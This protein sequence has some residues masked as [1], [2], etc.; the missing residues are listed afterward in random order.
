MLALTADDAEARLVPDLGG[1]LAGLWVDGKPVLRPWS[2]HESE[3]PFALACNILVP[4]SNRIAGGFTFQGT[5]HAMPPNLDIDPFAIHGDGFQKRWLIDE[6]DG[7]KAVLR[8]TDGA[9][10]PYRYEAV[11]TVTLTETRLTL[12]LDMTN[13]AAFALPY[14]GGFHP[15]FPRS[16]DT[17]LQFN[18]P[19]HWPE[20]ERHLPATD[21]PQAAPDD[22]DFTTAKPLPQRWIN[23]G[24][25]GWDG[26][27]CIVQGEDAVSL[28]VTSGLLTSAI[29][30]SP[31]PDCGFF[32]FEPVSHPVNAH[33][34][35]GLPGLA[36]LEPGKSLAMQMVLDWSGS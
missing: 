23:C 15:W 5:Y 3:G 11:Q 31:E 28:T 16:D 24:Y 30:Y 19:N 25:S 6:A 21:R 7:T 22:F 13:Q 1:G 17:V 27:A 34:L 8:L 14:G 33:N 4:F 12:E 20:D 2:G 32:C 18:A 10:G 9:F 35:P 36:I 26:R 29:V